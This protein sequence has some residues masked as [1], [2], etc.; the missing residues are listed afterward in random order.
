MTSGFPGTRLAD[1]AG[2]GV[3]PRL[4]GKPYRRRELAPILRET[5]ADP[6]PVLLDVSL[7][8]C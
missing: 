6:A 5:F 1:A 8:R 4:L 2:L 7:T 3:T